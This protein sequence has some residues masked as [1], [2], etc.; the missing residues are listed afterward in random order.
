MKKYI[1]SSNEG[2]K[3]LTK[4]GLGPGTLPNDVKLLDWEDKP[5]NLTEIWLDRFLTNQE[6]EYYDI[7]PETIQYET[8]Y[9]DEITANRHISYNRGGTKYSVNIE[10]EDINSFKA[11]I[12]EIHPY[13]DAE[14]AWARVGYNGYMNAEFVLDGNIID[15][16]QF[17]YYDDEYYES[18][19]EYLDYVID[20]ICVELKH[21]NKD[22]KPRMLYI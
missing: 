4:H 13:D 22:I 11:Q 12:S 14:Y 9:P 1:K 17:D 16:M 19:D 7:Y 20:E 21:I 10:D 15:R 8:L 6:L 18:E 2:Y 5:H 3:Y